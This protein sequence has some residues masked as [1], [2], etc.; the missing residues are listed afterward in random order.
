MRTVIFDDHGI[1]EKRNGVKTSIRVMFL[2]CAVQLSGKSL[3]GAV[4]KACA[5]P[6]PVHST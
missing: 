2:R 1:V 4:E 6:V 3:I 5:F